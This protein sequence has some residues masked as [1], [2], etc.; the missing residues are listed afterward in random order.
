MA[1]A[2]RAV[3][4]RGLIPYRREH[5]LLLLVAAGQVALLVGTT[6]VPKDS[7]LRS[8]DRL[9]LVAAMARHTTAVLLA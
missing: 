2:V 3:T 7:R 4:C 8:L 5:R 1:V 9:R 6:L